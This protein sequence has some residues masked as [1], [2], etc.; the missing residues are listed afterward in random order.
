MIRATLIAGARQTFAAS[1]QYLYLRSADAPLAITAV[2]ADGRRSDHV[3]R[4]GEQLEMLAELVEITVQNSTA[5]P[6]A[7]VIE[8]GYGKFHPSQN[9]ND[10]Q[11]AGQ[12][13]TLQVEFVGPQP[14]ELDTSAPIPVAM[15]AGV[16]VTN[17]PVPAGPA[18]SLTSPAPVDAGGSIPANEAR[19]VLIVRARPDNAEPVWLASTEGR[20]L[21]LLPTDPPLQLETTAEVSVAGAVDDSVLWAELL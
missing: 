7:F 15:P 10:V 3:L 13:A 4:S 14:V 18:A 17:F 16:Q 20:G 2:L 21:L 12:S 11:I 1:G 9:G 19:R 6:A 8:T 5:A